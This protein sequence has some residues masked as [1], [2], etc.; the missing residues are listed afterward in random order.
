MSSNGEDD[1]HTSESFDPEPTTELAAGEPQTPLWL[2]AVGIALFVAVGLWAF[3]GDETDTG[4]ETSKPAASASTIANAAPPKPVAR[5]KTRVP[6]GKDRERIREAA[7]RRGLVP[8][9][10]KRPGH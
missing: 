8:P 3:S 2:P 9:R 6:R 1:T 4:A 7:R 10:G 5:P